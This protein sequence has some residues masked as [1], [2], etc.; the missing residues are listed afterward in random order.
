MIRC[1]FVVLL[2]FALGACRSAPQT[3]G[4]AGAGSLMEMT[5]FMRSEDGRAAYYMLDRDGV[6]QFA[7]GQS[8][9]G[10][11]TSP[12]GA[13]TADQRAGL[14]AIIRD[15]QLLDARGQFLGGEGTVEYRLSLRTPT[16]RNHLRTSD[17][18]TPG[19]AELYETL[20]AIRV[21]HN[22]GQVVQ[23]IQ[24]TIERHEGGVQKN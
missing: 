1:L 24:A 18:Q 10:K 15:Y 12:L 20:N 8:A 17:R 6:L 9:Y 19:V 13:L 4:D 14:D 16:G 11:A 2:V 22:Y 7:G 23:P 3:D 21:E 5:L